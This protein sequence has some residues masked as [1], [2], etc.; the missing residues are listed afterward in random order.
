MDSSTRSEGVRLATLLPDAHGVL[1]RR[2]NRF[3][4]TVDIMPPGERGVPVHVHDPGRL[5]ELL[6][7]G[8][9]VLLRRAPSPARKTSW[10]LVAARR[11]GV[12]VL[13]NA[14]YHRAVASEAL[15]RGLVPGI[16]PGD[17]LE[18]EVRRGDS[19]LD[20]RTVG[21]CGTT[22]VEVKGC[23]LVQD[24]LALFPDAPSLR[25]SR[26][27]RELA[28]AARDGDGAVMLILV[29]GPAP[30]AFSPNRETD[31]A[32]FDAFYDAL[33]AGVRAVALGISYDGSHLACTGT[34]PV[35]SRCR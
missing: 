11:D 19:R 21:S 25:A 23:S 15:R 20:F 27:A 32:F 12:W 18:A 8:N 35:L 34:V 33:D 28:T 31:P 29:L 22:W 1:V 6:Y 10:D 5:K 7:P 4:A 16:V 14:S 9:E 17:R 2:E 3:L 24:G 26:H 30:Y 13:V